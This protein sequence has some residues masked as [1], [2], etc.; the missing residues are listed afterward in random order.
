MLRWLVSRGWHGWVLLLGV[1]LAFDITAAL[2]GGEPMTDSVRRAFHQPFARW[3]VI[4][5]IAFLV[6]HLTV[7]PSRIDPLD[8][9]YMW[10]RERRDKPHFDM[11]TPK[12]VREH[13]GNGS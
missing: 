6:L 4:A 9:A 3:V 5:T 10:V 12:F 1:V 2:L 8:R 13:S 7:L 11:P